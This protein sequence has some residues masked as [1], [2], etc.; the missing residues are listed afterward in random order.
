[1]QRVRVHEIVNTITT[2]Y[3]LGEHSHPVTL[4]AAYGLVSVTVI[5]I[6]LASRAAPVS[7]ARIDQLTRSSRTN[8]FSRMLND[9]PRLIGTSCVV[10]GTNR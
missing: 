5:R 7:I 1:M 6:D 4:R 10:R 3:Q 2:A 9:A 8:A